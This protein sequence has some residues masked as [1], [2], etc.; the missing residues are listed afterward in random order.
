MVYDFNKLFYELPPLVIFL[1]F[2]G[3]APGQSRLIDTRGYTYMR[4]I[5]IIVISICGSKP[6]SSKT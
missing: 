4:E 1:F 6:L 3:F 5:D 2:L